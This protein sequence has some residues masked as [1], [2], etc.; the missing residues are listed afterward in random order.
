MFKGIS[1]DYT[2]ATVLI[3]GGSNGIGLACAK[4]YR[5]AGAEV[6]LTGR[7]PKAE[8]Y[9]HDLSG[10]IY[11]PLDV[12]D[13]S[14]LIDLANSLDTLDILIN[15]AGGTQ[16]DE[17][18]HDGFDQSLA[19]NLNSA[20]HLSTACRPLLEASEW[21]GGASIIG[22]ASMT[23]YF[24]SAWTP[25]YGP[26]KAGIVQLMKTFGHNWGQYGIRANA[27]AAGLTRTNLVAPV[28]EH[29]PDMVD[30]TLTRQGIKRL[31]EAEDIAAAVLFLTSP[32]ASW[33]TGQTLPVDG[34]FTVGM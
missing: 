14:A 10:F 11:T 22:I 13:R 19:I 6:I 21:E 25:A 28:I 17:W 24:G 12:S 34:G 7:R 31:G 33:I 2:G 27:V 4:A 32:A 23:S 18:E 15:N 16:A 3:T 30:E 8:D 1:F 26:A 20:F 5:D 29:M 9:D